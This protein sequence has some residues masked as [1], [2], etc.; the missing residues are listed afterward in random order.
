[1]RKKKALKNIFSSLASQLVTVICGFIV[2]KLIISN[3]GSSVNGLINSIT[4]FLTYIVLF[5]SGFGPVVESILYKPIANKNKEE[6]TKILNATS[7]FFRRIS[8]IFIIYILI[9]C[10]IYPMIINSNFDCVFTISL[11]LIISSSLFAE[12]FFGMTFRIFLTADQKTY[13]VSLIKIVTTI[14]NALLIIILVKLNYNIQI[15][16]LVSSL[17]F[18]LRPLLQMIYVKKHYDISIKEAD[19]DYKIKQKWDGLAQHIAAVIHGNTDIAILTIFS[20]LKEVSVYSVYDLVVKGLRNVVVSIT[21]GVKASFGNLMAKENSKVLNEK[22]N[23]YEIL[24][25]TVTTIMFS[26]SMILIVPFIKVY[27]SNITDTNYIRP[28]FGLIIIYSEYINSIKNVYGSL[29]LAA[30]H[31]K[32]TK[33]GAWLEAIVNLLISLILVFKYGIVGVAVGTLI[34]MFIRMIEFIYHFSNYVLQRKFIVSFTKVT[35]SII[36]TFICYFLIRNLIVYNVVDFFSWVVYA[37]IVVILSSIVVF[38]INLPFIYKYI[39]KL[40]DKI[41]GRR[42]KIYE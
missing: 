6:I 15:V 2:P 20:T 38:I 27:T 31:F 33:K 37:I 41:L 5:E 19:N 1:M 10:V 3:Y 8:F 29:V 22:F 18:I 23:V 36:E 7:R 4:Q 39:L 11:I 12:Y 24:V 25:L 17:I 32:E 26:S 9:L 13:V 30:G 40:K 21:G 16:K 35:T 14:I 42:K 34:A 28:L